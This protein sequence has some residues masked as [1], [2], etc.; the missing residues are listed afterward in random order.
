MCEAHIGT[1]IGT[2]SHVRADGSSL[3]WGERF[4][5]NEWARVE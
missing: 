1:T 5:D 3:R 4:L 2:G